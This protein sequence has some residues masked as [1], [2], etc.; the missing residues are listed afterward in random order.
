MATDCD[1]KT[2]ILDLRTKKCLKKKSKQGSELSFLINICDDYPAINSKCEEINKLYNSGL[3]KSFK[4]GMKKF[5]V[6]VS[7]V[8]AYNLILLVLLVPV[9]N[10][11]IIVSYIYK[12]IIESNKDLEIISESMRKFN[13]TYDFVT[14][15][16]APIYNYFATNT[17]ANI[18][19]EIDKEELRIPGGWV[20]NDQVIPP[21]RIT[22][23]QAKNLVDNL[24]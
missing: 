22:L 12:K 23:P 21:T 18:L 9:K 8:L 15:T 16:G 1:S 5:I 3:V 17:T 20:G 7:V 6:P 2:E 14:S 10:R 4:K 11:E 13:K 24:L 19:D